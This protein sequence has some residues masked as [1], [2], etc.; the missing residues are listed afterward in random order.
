M[1]RDSY[2]FWESHN[3]I[4]AEVERAQ[5]MAE[6]ANLAE[7]R[8]RHLKEIMEWSITEIRENR[9]KQQEIA[10]KEARKNCINPTPIDARPFWDTVTMRPIAMPAKR[11]IFERFLSWLR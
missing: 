8:A 4:N 5:R 1:N 11:G 6:L 3:G 7:Y 10:E 2:G 9:K